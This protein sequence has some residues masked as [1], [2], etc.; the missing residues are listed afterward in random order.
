MKIL[1]KSHFFSGARFFLSSF[2]ILFNISSSAGPAPQLAHM[3]SLLKSCMNSCDSTEPATTTTT[4]ATTAA[5]AAAED[6]T[7]NSNNFLESVARHGDNSKD[8][9][10]MVT[11]SGE[12]IVTSRLWSGNRKNTT[13]IQR[14]S[15]VFNKERRRS[16]RMVRINFFKIR[17]N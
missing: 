9:S 3:R 13:W 10:N 14:M 11:S 15:N 4:T 12:N 17:F 6:H 8:D 2:F 7:G 16:E 5:T 1:N